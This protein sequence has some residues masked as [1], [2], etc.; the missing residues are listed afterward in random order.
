MTDGIGQMG[1]GQDDMR[2]VG[3]DLQHAKNLEMER[4]S[5]GEQMRKKDW[6]RFVNRPYDS[7][8]KY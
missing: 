8:H 3:Q 7:Q 6:E 4:H 1:A 2:M 5:Q